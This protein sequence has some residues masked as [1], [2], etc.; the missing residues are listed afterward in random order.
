MPLS[1]F[2]LVFSRVSRNHCG[3]VSTD[4][5][6][7]TSMHNT[8]I[9]RLP[10]DTINYGTTQVQSQLRTEVFRSLKPRWT[11]LRSSLLTFEKKALRM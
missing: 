8:E 11:R 1:W 3:P 6:C 9:S 2:S 5:R 7:R 4:Q 10:E